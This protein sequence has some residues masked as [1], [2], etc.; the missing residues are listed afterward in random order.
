MNNKKIKICN[1]TYALHQ[2]SSQL[3]QCHMNVA[4]T[5]FKSSSWL[6]QINSKSELMCLMLDFQ[7]LKILALETRHGRFETMPIYFNSQISLILKIQDFTR[8]FHRSL[9]FMKS[10]T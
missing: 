6:N 10:S 4:L 9:Y 8:P 5:T 7:S 2:L 3:L 1:S